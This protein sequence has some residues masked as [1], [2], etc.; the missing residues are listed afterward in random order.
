VP[1]VSYRPVEAGRAGSTVLGLLL[2][3]AVGLALGVLTAYAQEWLPQE[4]GSLANSS[5]TWALIAFALA[6]LAAGTRAAALFGCVALLALLL[7]YVLGAN[8][9]GF[10]SGSSLVVFW[11]GAAVVVGP[12]LGV[13]AQ[14][15]R[16]GRGMAAAVGIGMISGV[17]AGEGVY[18]LAYIAGTTYPPF[19]W[20]E[21]LVGVALLVVVAGARLAGA[22][23][24]LVAVAVAAMTALAFVAVYSQNLISVLP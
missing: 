6:L 5:G 2:V 14:R 16:A 10:A 19:W 4:L 22:R 9:R 1:A 15:V 3:G 21:A 18:G 8:A 12:V 23:A 13:A 7:G 24:R 20:G 17:L 11:G